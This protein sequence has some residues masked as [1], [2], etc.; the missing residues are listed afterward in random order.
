MHPLTL[1]LALLLPLT[2]SAAPLPDKG[3]EADNLD[4]V[5]YVT[6]S[7]FDGREVTSTDQGQTYAFK[8]NKVECKRGE[9][10][11][12]F[13]VRIK[14]GDI[15]FIP[16][17]GPRKGKTL[18]GIYKLDGETLLICMRGVPREVNPDCIRPTKFDAPENSLQLFL[19]L[20]RKKIDKP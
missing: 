11:S 10:V 16:Q 17:F 8:G 4:G 12:T 18:E 9:T 2:M 7:K 6:K 13:E 20:K 1:T 14:S 3:K 19:T 15:D 5:W